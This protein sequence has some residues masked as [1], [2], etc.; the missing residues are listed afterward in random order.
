MRYRCCNLIHNLITGMPPDPNPPDPPETGTMYSFYLPSEES[1]LEITP[2]GYPPFQWSY[3]AG[4]WAAFVSGNSLIGGEITADP[5]ISSYGDAGWILT[6]M[7]MSGWTYIDMNNP[8]PPIQMF[9]SGG[10]VNP[11]LKCYVNDQDG[12]PIDSS[13]AAGIFLTSAL[14][15]DQFI[16]NYGGSLPLITL[17]D[18]SF[19]A[20]VDGY[21]KIAFGSQA[22]YTQTIVGTS[23]TCRINNSYLSVGG[24]RFKTAID[25]SDYNP[26]QNAIIETTCP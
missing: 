25:G 4:S 1:L 13:V 8:G 7:D 11:Q 5:T 16:N 22:S 26:P 12:V 15:V 14:G 20:T 19:E 18:P 17:D 23:F 6:Q 9:P 2:V 3:G 21:V 24:I 10:E